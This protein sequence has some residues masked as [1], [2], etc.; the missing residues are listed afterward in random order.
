MKRTA[1]LCMI[2]LFACGIECPITNGPVCTEVFVYGVNVTL[3]DT[4]TGEPVTGATLVLSE[5][6]YTETMRE[7]TPGQYVGAGERPGTYELTV[8]AE[9]F[10]PE[11]RSMI[12]VTADECHVI[13]VNLDIALTPLP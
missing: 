2:P 6:T 10:L 1:I 8:E 13:P 7:I 5:A 12:V 9:G 4:E 3:T 11:S